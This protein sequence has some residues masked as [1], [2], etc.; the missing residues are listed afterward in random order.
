MPEVPAGDIG[1]VAKLGDTATGDTLAP[2]GTPVV[3]PPPRAAGAGAVD[4]HPPQVQG[5]RGQADDRACTACRTRTRP[6]HVRRD[7][8]THQ[9][10]LSGMGETHLAIVTER[11]HRKFGVEVETEDVKVPYR[12]TITGD[13]RGRGQVQEADRRPR[14]VRRGLPAVEP[15]ERGG[16]FEFVDK[17]VGGAIPR[18]FIPAVEKGIA[19]TMSTGGVFGYPVV[20]VRVTVLRRQVPL[21]RLV[22]DE[23]QD[24]GLARASGRPWPRPAR[25]CSSRSR[26]SRSPCPLDVPGRRH[27]RPQLP[28]GPGAGHRGG[29]QRRADDHRPGADV[30]DPA[31]RHRPA[32]D[33]RRAGPVHRRATTTTTRSRPTSS[34]RWPR[35]TASERP[36]RLRGVRVRLRPVSAG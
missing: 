35:P 2:K 24:G 9:T 15:L 12:E 1:A 32:L 25:C 5:R 33:H 29:R 10:L 27:G 28:A 26:C 20:D 13:G 23:L 4:R 22:G 30:G 14:P 19:E 16:G 8:E 6:S 21:G 3:V 31:L 11:L 17:I 7:D 18:Q 34:T 36:S